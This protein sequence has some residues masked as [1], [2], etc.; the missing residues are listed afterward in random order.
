M[1]Q[2]SSNNSSTNISVQVAL[3]LHYLRFIAAIHMHS[4][5]NELTFF[6]EKNKNDD[7]KIQNEC[8]T[9]RHNKDK[10]KLMQKATTITASTTTTKY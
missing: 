1:V 6:V 9:A 5:E 3:Y 10:N 4:T 8:T 2:R 7:I